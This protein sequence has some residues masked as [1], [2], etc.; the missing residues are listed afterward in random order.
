MHKHAF[1]HCIM[2]LT[3]LTFT[4]HACT[5]SVPAGITHSC[6]CMPHMH[7]DISQFT[8]DACIP[9]YIYTCGFRAPILALVCAPRPH[10]SLR[11]TPALAHNC[12]QGAHSNLELKST[13]SINMMTAASCNILLFDTYPYMHCKL[14][15]PLN[16]FK[17][18]CRSCQSGMWLQHTLILHTYR[19]TS[20][21][22]MPATSHALLT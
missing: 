8:I 15:S 19:R 14:W 6:T 1:V 7:H 9:S 5:G 21:P 17:D 18:A 2:L 16:S 22:K 13:P 11:Q 4:L 3:C 12:L 10:R 20:P